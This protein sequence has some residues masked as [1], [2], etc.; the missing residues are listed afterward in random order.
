L[1]G[2]RAELVA[3]NFSFP[4]SAA[5]DDEGRVFIAESGLSFGGASP[6][7]RIWSVGADGRRSLVAGG[8]RPPVNGLT[9]QEGALYVSEGGYPGRISR[10]SRGGTLT[11]ILDNLPG[12]GNYHTNMTVFGPDGKLYFS[13]GAMTNS[14]VVGLDALGLGWLRKLPH[15]HDLPGIEVVLAGQE[16]E[17]PDPLGAE[18][19]RATTGAFMPFGTRGER[20]TR[21]ARRLP[22]TS[23][24]MR[25][26]PTGSGLELV[27][28]GLRNAYGLAFLAD[29]RLL[30]VDQGP[31]DRGSRPIGNAPDLLYEVRVGSWY[32]WPDFIGGVPVTAPEFLPERGPQPAFLLANHDDLPPPQLPLLRFPAHSAAVK[33]T[34][35]PET[36]EWKGLILVAL[37]GDERPMTAPAGPRA[38]RSLAAINPTDWT[39]QYL[40]G[41]FERPI[42]VAYNALDDRV[43]V[44]DFGQFEM[45]A[46]NSLT[47][48]PGSGRLFRLNRAE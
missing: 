1:S 42:D 12:P 23:G 28:W 10:L 33:L 39:F 48:T 2:F 9:W 32:G 3:G 46:D 36:S 20:G 44:V 21:V 4:T 37:F 35:T 5:F 30:A 47:A 22:C 13:Q 38:G 40:Y 27:A 19:A 17:T 8:L 29:G 7:G 26:D 34:A 25:C 43:Y 16:F 11:T 24:V 31:D 45:N 6:G 14:G 15:A 18:G 41:T